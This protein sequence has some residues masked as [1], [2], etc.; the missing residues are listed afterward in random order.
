MGEKL[1]PKMKIC[2]REHAFP[3]FMREKSKL[4]LAQFKV[5]SFGEK[6]MSSKPIMIWLSGISTENNGKVS[7]VDHQPIFF[8]TVEDAL[9][10]KG[11]EQL[12]FSDGYVYPLTT[13][14]EMLATEKDIEKRK[15]E[16]RERA[17]YYINTRKRLTP[18]MAIFAAK[19]GL[20]VDPDLIVDAI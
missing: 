11:V 13:K 3:K 19:K 8:G 12:I 6:D 1:D 14:L 16:E 2:R 15:T 9:A 17:E 10:A 18:K 5:S 7:P 4:R 20:S